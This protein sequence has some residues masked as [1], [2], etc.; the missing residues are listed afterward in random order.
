MTELDRELQR[1]IVD[2][3]VGILDPFF[4]AL[5]AVGS[6]G[7][8]WLAIGL[9]AGLR[10]R[11]PW[12]VLLVATGVLAA[13]LISLALKLSF[14]RERPSV[15]DAEQD[16]LVSTPLGLSF[17]SGHSSTSFAAATILAAYLPALAL[18]LYALA[19]LVAVSRV[20]VGVHYPLDIVGGALLGVA[21]GLAVLAL[22]GRRRLPWLRRLSPPVR[23]PRSP[24][25]ARPRSPRGRRRD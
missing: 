12:L 22:V 20:Y 16:P 7:L 18:P 6:F 10:Q 15:A 25:A 14:G 11:R 23:S 17:P 2:H 1:W 19:A 21:V 8:V 3:R 9:A 24:P 13:D 4:V 5:S